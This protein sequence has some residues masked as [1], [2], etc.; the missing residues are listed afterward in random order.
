MRK[1]LLG[2]FVVI[3][4]LFCVGV[5]LFP[6]I[7]VNNVRFASMPRASVHKI[8]VEVDDKPAGN[9]SGV[10]IAPMLM[11]TAA[12]VA[13]AGPVLTV[14]G[15]RA[16]VRVLRVDPVKDLALLMVA[17]GCPC[18]DL[19]TGPIKV[20]RAVTTVG[21]PYNHIL[22]TQVLTE[23]RVQGTNSEGGTIITSPVARGNSGGGVFIKEHG[24]Y[25]LVG[26][27]V[28]VVQA[29]VFGGAVAH[30]ASAAS[31]EQINEFLANRAP[32]ELDSVQP[33]TVE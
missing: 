22:G 4:V 26:I 32:A 6:Q 29:N 2:L 9:G 5:I 3:A 17:V 23:G 24:R 19:A 10:M 20:D 31:L 21:F 16:P 8:V 30:L 33:G 27:V 7:E 12:H 25:K 28:G 11:L 15:E 18:A 14:D 1:Y 13:K